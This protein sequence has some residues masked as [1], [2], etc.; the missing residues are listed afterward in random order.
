MLVVVVLFWLLFFCY[1]CH[2]GCYR[3]YHRCSFGYCSFVIVIVG[4]VIIDVIDL[5]ILSLLL[6]LL[7]SF[8]FWLLFFRYGYH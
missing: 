1:C 3:Y 5:V 4:V 2:W 8:L 7:L 6:L